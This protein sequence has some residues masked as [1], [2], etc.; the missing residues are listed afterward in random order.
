[1]PSRESQELRSQICIKDG[2]THKL[3]VATK[4]PPRHRPLWQPPHWARPFNENTTSVP[5]SNRNRDSNLLPPD[6]RMTNCWATPLGP[7]KQKLGRAIPGILG[8]ESRCKREPL[9]HIYRGFTKTNPVHNPCIYF[10]V[11]AT[12]RYFEWA[13][14]MT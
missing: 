5:R 13:I 3:W 6:V 1:M 10:E 9:L 8:I 11:Q 7:A 2:S 12:L 4:P 14:F